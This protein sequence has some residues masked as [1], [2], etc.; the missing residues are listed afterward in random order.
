MHTYR[1]FLLLFLQPKLGSSCSFSAFERSWT[2]EIL[3]CQSP[4]FHL[5]ADTLRVKN[6]QIMG[7]EWNTANKCYCFSRWKRNTLYNCLQIQWVCYDAKCMFGCH[8]FCLL[9][10]EHKIADK[11][12]LKK[13]KARFIKNRSMLFSSPPTFITPPSHHNMINSESSFIK[14]WN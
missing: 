5:T 2:F 3:N 7:V 6:T 10:A 11:K 4:S 1:G 13:H 9:P 8:H 12:K 14:A